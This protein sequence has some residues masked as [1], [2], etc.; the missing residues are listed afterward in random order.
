MSLSATWKDQTEALSW[1]VQHL[2]AQN[3]VLCLWRSCYK[4][5]WKLLCLLCAKNMGTIWVPEILWQ[6]WI[7]RRRDMKCFLGIYIPSNG[8]NITAQKPCYC[9]TD[10]SWLTPSMPFGSLCNN[11]GWGSWWRNWNYFCANFFIFQEV[12]ISL[13]LKQTETKLIL[14]QIQHQKQHQETTKFTS[15]VFEGYWSVKVKSVSNNVST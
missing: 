14:N 15:F 13:M 8:R 7:S 4:Q 3:V 12:E 10:V 11:L 5:G 6:I 9:L 1:S 2:Y